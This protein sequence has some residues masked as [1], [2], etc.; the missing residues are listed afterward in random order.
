MPDKIF[1]HVN[2][3]TAGNF[4]LDELESHHFIKALR[5]SKGTVIWLTD[6][7]GTVYKAIVENM[8]NHKVN[9]RIVDKFSN[10]GENNFI[11]NLGVGILKNGKMEIVVEKAT[12]NGTNKI[13][14]IIMDRSIKRDVNVERLNKIAF[15]AVKQCGR[16]I[17]PQISNPIKFT[18]YIEG[19]SENILVF[20]ESGKS[21]DSD[22]KKSINE[23]KDI[24]ILIGPEGDFS[25]SELDGLKSRNAT[26]LNLGNR[27]LRSETAV[28]TALSQ[29]NLI[30]Q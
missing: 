8:E 7:V 18:E 6:G 26:F 15:T 19:I 12:E 1:F 2:K 16:S 10:Y 17:I 14:P 24:N 21:I 28:I 11:L 4:Y 29:L 3:I 13:I 22:I 20:H 27:R 25:D 5:K 23:Q 30:L 9:G